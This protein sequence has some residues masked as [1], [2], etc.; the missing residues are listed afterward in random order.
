MFLVAVGD[1]GVSVGGRMGVKHPDIQVGSLKAASPETIHRNVKSIGVG[2]KTAYSLASCPCRLGTRLT[3]V[4]L[5]T[6][7]YSIYCRLSLGN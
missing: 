1:A 6:I 5:V 2:D 7:L 3:V 4:L